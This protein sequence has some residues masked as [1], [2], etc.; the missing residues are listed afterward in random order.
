MNLRSAFAKDIFAQELLCVYEKQTE[1]RD[2]LR[3][4]SRE[5]IAEIVSKINSGTYD[6]PKLEEMLLQFADRLSKTSGKKQYG[7]LKDDVKAIVN[8]IVDELASDERIASLY[9]LWYEQKE[10]IL[11]TYTQELADW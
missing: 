6:N 9:D 3:S 5:V 1:H 7:Y 11:L 2:A 4:G 10:E 8:R